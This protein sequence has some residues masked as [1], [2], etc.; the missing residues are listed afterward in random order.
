MSTSSLLPRIPRNVLALMLFAEAG[1]LFAM[2]AGAQTTAPAPPPTVQQG[3]FGVT[4]LPQDPPPTGQQAPLPSPAAPIPN[5]EKAI[6]TSPDPHT[7]VAHLRTQPMTIHDAVAIALSTNRQLTLAEEALRRAQGRTSETRSALNPTLGANASYTRLDS[8]Q[9]TTLGNRSVTIVNPDQPS[10]GLAATLPIDISGLLRTATEQAQFTEIAARL[11]VNRARN[12][13]VL[14]VKSAFYDVLRDQAL[15]HVAQVNLQAS[16]DRLSDSTKRYRAGI[17]ARFDV[18]R[19][20]TDVAN[21][22]QQLISARATV[23]SAFAA[24]NSTIG[25]D[26]NSPITITDQGAVENPP[27]VAPPADLSAPATPRPNVGDLNAPA[28]TGAPDV[29]PS[30]A[31]IMPP[32]PMIPPVVS[33]PMVFGP[34][35]SAILRE[36]QATRPE[37]LEADANIA[38]ARKGI[39]L[40]HRSSLPTLGVSAGATYNPIPGGFT[41]KQVTGQIGIAVSLPIFDGGISRARVTEARA[42]VATAETNRR[43]MI[44]LINLELRQ[45][46]LALSQSRDRV[47]VANQ[48]VSEAREGFRLARVRYTEGVSGT[49]GISPLLEVSDAQAALVQA[50]SNQVNALYD[51][52]NSRARLDKAIGRYSYTSAPGY[53]APP[54]PKTVGNPTPGAPK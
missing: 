48:A 4:P 22:Q 31:G 47:A 50:E 26:V 24:L 14:D 1:L 17:V 6:R 32:E 20:Q 11:D 54:S 44:D 40:A 53:T 2:P 36:T 46:Y 52:N 51:Y 43:Q 9:S 41:T 10:F 16:L 8:G 21:A 28:D 34:D 39:Q 13:A 3:P 38:A 49:V 27:G 30:P 29:A 5:P 42:E 18:I 35:Y 23:S 12:Q 33:D 7:I 15:V 19:A 25:V 37:I 45:V